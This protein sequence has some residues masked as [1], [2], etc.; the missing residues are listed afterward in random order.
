LLF[1]TLLLFS[2]FVQP[3]R[4]EAPDR[5]APP[6]RG[7]DGYQPQPL[8]RSTLPLPR[9]MLPQARSDGL[10]AVAIVGDVGSSTSTY[11]ND[12]DVAVN[13]LQ[14]H[15]VSVEKFYYG[16]STF[17]WSDIVAAAQ[18]AHFLIY[19][20][21]GVYWSGSCTSPTLVGGFYLASGKYVHPDQIRSDLAG[22]MAEDSVVILSHVCFSAGS[23]ACD[24]SGEPSQ[25]EAERRVRMYAAPFVDIGMQAYFANNYFN[26]SANIVN[27]LLVDPASRQNVGDIFKSVYPYSASEF[28]D[29]TYPDAPGYDLWLSGTTGHW[30][31]AFVGIPGYVFDPSG[32]PE[33]GQL[34]ASLAFAYNTATTLLSPA[35][36]V[37]TPQNVGDGGALT[38]SVTMEGGWFTAAPVTGDTSSDQLTIAPVTSTIAGFSAGHYTGAFTVT[39]TDPPGTANGV[40]RVNLGLDVLTPRLGP[41]SQSLSFV[42]FFS[43]TTFLPTAYY[44]T[45][46]NVGT[47]DTLTWQLAYSGDW[48]TVSPTNGKTPDAFTIAPAGIAITEPVTCTDLVTLTVTDPL[49]T[50]D[51]VQVIS[52]TLRTQPGG[53]AYLYMPLVMRD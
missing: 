17:A 38:W 49:G 33:L 9:P 16:D 30:S 52:V 19:M 1:G 12:M 50:Q 6:L 37:L 23:T 45:P 25:D 48:L 4:S 20:G 26:S 3:A 31:H 14:N 39:V 32:N 46:E 24:G 43:D 28:R 36:H 2:L 42:Y 53:P 47:G 27:R 8:D 41:I 40:Q 34:P 15:G 7:P 22:W 44:I 21:H 11:K 35:T 18:G 29:L 5:I 10:K 51:A 13:A